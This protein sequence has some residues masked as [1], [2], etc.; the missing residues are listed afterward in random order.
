MDVLR[1]HAD[2]VIATEQIDLAPVRR[3]VQLVQELVHTRQGIRVL[4]SELVKGAVVHTKAQTTS[5]LAGKEDGRTKGRGGGADPA[6]VKVVLKLALQFLKLS[7][8]HAILTLL[9]DLSVG[10]EGNT[11]VAVT[12]GRETGWFGEHISVA[13]QDGLEGRWG[14]GRGLGR[15]WWGFGIFFGV[16]ERPKDAEVN[17]RCGIGVLLSG[18]GG[19]GAGAGGCLSST[20]DHVGGGGEFNSEGGGLVGD[21]GDDGVAN[22][23]GVGGP[24]NLGVDGGEP[25]FAED[26]IEAIQ[27]EGVEGGAFLVG[28]DGKVRVRERGGGEGDMS[29]GKADAESLGRWQ[30]SA[31]GPG[32]FGGGG[33]SLWR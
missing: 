29:V 13:V 28:G 26:S 23:D 21:M 12:G 32:G 16:V 10:D 22:G 18:I 27:V 9:G 8:G 7:G 6:T 19:G 4:D 31:D 3:T 2:E 11:V 1:S 25:G 17:R 15:L 30:S 20:L 33:G 14:E 5:L 24:V